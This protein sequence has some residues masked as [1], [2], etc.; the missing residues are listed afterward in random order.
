MHRSL[1]RLVTEGGWLCHNIMLG[2]HAF[3]GHSTQT[4]M[5]YE[6]MHRQHNVVLRQTVHNTST[7]LCTYVVQQL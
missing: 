7:V 4:A 6:C 1:K 5:P 3:I 2:V